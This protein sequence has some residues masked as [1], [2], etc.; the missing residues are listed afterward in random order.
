MLNKYTDYKQQ[1]LHASRLQLKLIKKK[2]KKLTPSEHQ[3]K[4]YKYMLKLGIP[5]AL[6]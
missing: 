5:V 2:N 3:V 4:M 6:V 1:M